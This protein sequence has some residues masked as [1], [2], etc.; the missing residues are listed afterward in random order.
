VAPAH[1]D[2][3]WTP[4]AVR[5]LHDDVVRIEEHDVETP[6]GRRYCFP[7]VRSPGFAKVVPLLPNGDVVLVRQYRPALDR[8]MWEIPAGMRDVPGEDPALT[9]ARELGEET[10][11]AAERLEPLGM[12]VSAS[13]V[14]DSAVVLYLGTG[15]REV[16]ADRHGPEERFM[17][18][19]RVPLDEA[20]AMVDRGEITDGKTVIGLLQALRRART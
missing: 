15:L 9:A 5:I 14:T 18:V 1:D 8:A 11:L 4:H 17:E 6:E 3:V 20:V 12:H 7:L 2:P 19:A 10:G 16:P 13:G